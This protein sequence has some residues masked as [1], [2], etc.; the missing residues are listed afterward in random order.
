[1]VDAPHNATADIV[2]VRIEHTTKR[3]TAKIKLREVARG[4]DYYTRIQTPTGTYRAT[5]HTNGQVEFHVKGS[6]TR[7]PERTATINKKKKNTVALHLPR[8]CI[9]D[10]DWV[11]LAINFVWFNDRTQASYGDQGF[12]VGHIWSDDGKTVFWTH[13]RR[14]RLEWLN[15]RPFLVRTIRLRDSLVQ[16]L[17]RAG[18]RI[19]VY[20]T[21]PVGP[22]TGQ[23][24]PR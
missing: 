6:Q 3:I 20:W 18:P 5:V 24:R 8:A 19:R 22:T 23:I 9:K 1:V 4:F 12:A 21:I 14:L 2:R 10:P 17:A 13:S 11:R 7:C 15:A 16:R